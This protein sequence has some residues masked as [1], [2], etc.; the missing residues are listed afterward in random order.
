MHTLNTFLVCITAVS[1]LTLPKRDPST[2]ISDVN[3]IDVG[4]K[5][6]TA[7]VETY[8]GGAFPTGLIDS[9]PILLDVIAIHIANRKGYADALL[10]PT[11]SA[12]D[13]TA[14]VEFVVDTVGVDIPAGVAVLKAKKAAFEA[15]GLDGTVVAS[16]TLLKSDHDSFSAALEQKLTTPDP[17]EAAAAT[18]VV[19]K[20]DQALADGIAYYSS[21]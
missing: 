6:L 17:A 16:L 2:L 13:S 11:L 9:T 19:A 5:A 14:V 15:A 21:S 20:I 7:N 12:S 18:G 4:V 1:A 8:N 10:S 3:N